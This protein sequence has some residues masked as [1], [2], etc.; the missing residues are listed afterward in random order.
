MNMPPEP[1]LPVLVDTT[2]S[3]RARG[4][5]GYLLQLRGP[6]H[7]TIQAITNAGTEGRDAVRSALRELEDA[8]YITRQRTQDDS[9]RMGWWMQT[10]FADDVARRILDERRGEAE[11]DQ[12]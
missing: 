6:G 8:G 1:M 7:A 9:G 11:A 4:I 12:P 2:L 10:H 5:A 3:F